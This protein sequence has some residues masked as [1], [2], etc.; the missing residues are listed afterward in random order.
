M[1]KVIIHNEPLPSIPLADGD[2]HFFII[3]VG[4]RVQLTAPDGEF[5]MMDG[6]EV[7]SLSASKTAVGNVSVENGI[8][9]D[10]IMKLLDTALRAVTP[11]K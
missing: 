11:N 3:G 2:Y 6:K 10:T 4:G 8:Q 9:E 1:N 5:W 7:P